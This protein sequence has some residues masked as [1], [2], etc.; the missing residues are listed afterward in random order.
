VKRF[1]TFLNKYKIRVLALLFITFSAVSSVYALEERMPSSKQEALAKI[2]EL[3][4]ALG[5]AKGQKRSKIIKKIAEIENK[6]LE[7]KAHS[8][9]K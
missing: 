7:R 9:N 1:F 3:K 4:K 5:F 8:F 6:V 2:T